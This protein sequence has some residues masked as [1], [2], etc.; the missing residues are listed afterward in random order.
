MYNYAFK[1]EQLFY[2]G[3]V[4]K[5]DEIKTGGAC[6]G[7]ETPARRRKYIY[8]SMPRCSLAAGQKSKIFHD[9]SGRGY[10]EVGKFPETLPRQNFLEP[11]GFKKW[12]RNKARKEGR[13]WRRQ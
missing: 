5:R 12:F 4:K 7:A 10:G 3:Y 11:V 8:T 9:P 13:M 1:G 6:A 2:Y